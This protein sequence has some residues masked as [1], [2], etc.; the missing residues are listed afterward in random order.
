MIDLKV[1]Y[2]QIHSCEFEGFYIWF[3]GQSL[4]YKEAPIPTDWKFSEHKQ[5]LFLASYLEF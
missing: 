2:L 3:S 1:P 5:I 4:H